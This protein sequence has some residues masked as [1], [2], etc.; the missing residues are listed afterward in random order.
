VWFVGP[1]NGNHLRC[2][3][4]HILHHPGD[5][6]GLSGVLTVRDTVFTLN[7]KTYKAVSIDQKKVNMVENSW[8][9][10]L[11]EGV[12]PCARFG[13]SAAAVVGSSFSETWTLRKKTN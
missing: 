8:S 5:T 13:K 7:S 3:N 10:T 1:V 12:G 6:A 4:E 2:G 9:L 11:A